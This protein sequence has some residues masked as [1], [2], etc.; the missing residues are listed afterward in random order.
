MAWGLLLLCIVLGSLGALRPSGRSH[1]FRRI[2]E[3]E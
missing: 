3:E 1:D 2:K